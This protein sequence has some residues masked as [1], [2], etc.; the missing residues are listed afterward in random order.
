[1]SSARTIA[2]N[3]GVFFTADI[4]SRLISFLIIVMLARFLGEV[5][6]G[7][8]AFVVAFVWILSTLT[9]LG[10][11]TLLVREIARNKA[12]TIK[13]LK[14]A[15][16]LKL[17]LG[18]AMMIISFIVILFFNKPLD[19][20][21]MVYLAIIS[22][23]LSQ[24][25]LSFKALFQAYEVMEYEAITRLVERVIAI[26]LGFYLLSHNYG[27]IS[28]FV[29]LILSQAVS[30]ILSFILVHKKIVKISIGVDL[31]TWK[32]LLKY[33]LP[34]WF[35]FVFSL[36]YFKVDTVMLSLMKG[37][38]V[39]GWY[40]A[41]YN[42]AIA[43][44][45]IPVAIAVSVFPVFS[46]YFKTKKKL[47]KALYKK[48]FYYSVALALP[49][50]AGGFLLSKKLILFIYGDSF[51]PHSVIALQILIFS[52]I[53]LFLSYLS[54]QVLNSIRKPHLFAYSTATCLVL[55]IV[56]NFI[57]IP[58]MSYR[59]ASISTV[60]AEALNFFILFYFVSKFIGKIELK[61]IFPKPLIASI[62]MG[63]FIYILR[64]Q[65][66]I[67]LVIGSVLVYF[68]ALFLIKGIDKEDIKSV[69]LRKSM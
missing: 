1:M 20:I 30:F 57:L 34:F 14:N 52:S 26:S 32:Y 38:A 9:D 54:G 28:F 23:F 19:V 33:S 12:K 58:S 16:S 31:K 18:I 49:I 2:K 41:A 46:K 47:F 5:G 22:T 65:N 43:L 35:T 37:D 69:L 24:Y 8:Y 50:I 13:Y 61:E 53:F 62:L 59:G 17:V 64:E 66:I 63:L 27:L 60:I 6:L 42:I 68:A 51:I 40:N 7:K 45:V 15:L 36:I 4:I 55:N 67:F 10:I 48:A 21:I 29:V 39:V 3:A 25:S 44:N 11:S 56:L